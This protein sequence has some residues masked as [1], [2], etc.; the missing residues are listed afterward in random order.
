MTSLVK[1]LQIS[2]CDLFVEPYNIQVCTFRL[3]TFTLEYYSN[4]LAQLPL[5]SPK[6]RSKIHISYR[7]RR[8]T[9]RPFVCSALDSITQRAVAYDYNIGTLPLLML[10]WKT[11]RWC[12]VQIS[13]L[14]SVRSSEIDSAQEKTSEC[15]WPGVINSESLNCF[16]VNR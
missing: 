10:Q 8:P 6:E 14:K 1:N 11:G 2:V 5:H 12:S 9:L 15:G 3:V 16:A 4:L 7:Q 13:K